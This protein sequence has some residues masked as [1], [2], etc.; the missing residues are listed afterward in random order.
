MP[1]TDPIPDTWPDCVS[2]GL[3]CHW[4]AKRT[5]AALRA[6]VAE[7]DEALI[8]ALARVAEVERDPWLDEPLTDSERAAVDSADT[9]EGVP[10]T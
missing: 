3:K 10:W 5:I 9:K 1:P 8:A 7:Q 4:C 2:C 6:R